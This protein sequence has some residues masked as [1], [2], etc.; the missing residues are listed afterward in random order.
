MFTAGNSVLFGEGL[1]TEEI[2]GRRD[3]NETLNRH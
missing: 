3:G 2:V 1:N